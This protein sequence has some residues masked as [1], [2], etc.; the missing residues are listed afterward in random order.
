MNNRCPRRQL[1]QL[2]S[3]FLVGACATATPPGGLHE[4]PAP[5]CLAQLGQ[6]VAMPFNVY[7][8]SKGVPLSGLAMAEDVSTILTNNPR[9]KML[10]FMQYKKLIEEYNI[11]YGGMVSDEHKLE[12]AAQLGADTA[13]L[14]SVHVQGRGA[15]RLNL[16]LV[17]IKTR[18]ACIAESAIGS[19]S[20]LFRL[21]DELVAKL[22]ARMAMLGR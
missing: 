2:A 10:E 21:E 9:F 4:E 1:T 16:R 17:L 6:I 20:D 14:G 3:F 12:L 13:L 22:S 5:T 8:V 15:L 11:Q 19:E 18:T 7:D